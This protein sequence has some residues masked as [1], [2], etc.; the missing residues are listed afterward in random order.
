[1]ELNIYPQDEK[2]DPKEYKKEI[3][4]LKKVKKQILEYMREHGAKDNEGG[5]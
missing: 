4:E 2:V 1:M 5:F 3:E